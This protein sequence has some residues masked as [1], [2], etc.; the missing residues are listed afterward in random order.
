MV[1]LSALVKYLD[2]LLRVTEWKN[3]DSSFNGLQVEGSK[4]VSL[5][6]FAVDACEQTFALCRETG[7]QMLIAHHGLFWG[8]PLP[9]TGVHLR[10]VRL[11]LDSG[12]SLYAA[13]MPL[14]F[15]PVLGHNACIAR[16]LELETK[17]PLTYEKGLPIGILARSDKPL[18]LS[19]FIRRVD[20]S[21]QTSCRLLSFGP[22]MIQQ[23]GIASGHGSRLLDQ[24]LSARIDT[25]LTGESSHTIYHFARE[26]GVNVIFAG[27]YATEMPG[28]KELSFHLAEHFRLET[29]I[30]QAPT[31]L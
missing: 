10:R 24:A 30:L 19:Q 1:K 13:H 16:I 21:L 9:L 31:G 4:D 2:D 25:F 7:A 15:H 14:D 12:I 23:I 6:A 22:K 5:V 26:F 8:E 17:E 28:L 11:L 18:E 3:A 27:H 29:R 20:S